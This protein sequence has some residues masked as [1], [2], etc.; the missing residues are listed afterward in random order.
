MSRNDQTGQQATSSGQIPPITNISIN[1]TDREPGEIQESQTNLNSNSTPQQSATQSTISNF[2]SGISEANIRRRMQLETFISD[3]R[4]RRQTRAK[5]YSA[6]LGELENEP[7]LS[8][9]EKETTFQLYS[10]E[11]DLAKTRTQN[12]L[13]TARIRAETGTNLDPN[14]TR[15][16]LAPKQACPFRR[17]SRRS[18]N[19]SESESE[20]ENSKKKPQLDETDMPWHKKEDYETLGINPSCLKTIELLQLY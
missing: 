16:T 9:Q 11:V 1:K 7:R 20:G 6:I 4:G 14:T 13:A 5:T 12:Q 2:P 18:V 8:S 15:E 3:Y 17:E 10:A 19:G